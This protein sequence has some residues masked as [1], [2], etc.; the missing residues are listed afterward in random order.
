[1]TAL[2]PQPPLR[3][4]WRS[5]GAVFAGLLAVF[6][7]SLGTGPPHKLKLP[8]RTSLRERAGRRFARSVHHDCPAHPGPRGTVNRAVIGVGPHL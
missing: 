7:L 1:M 4:P 3:R 8:K 2:D 5:A 6:V